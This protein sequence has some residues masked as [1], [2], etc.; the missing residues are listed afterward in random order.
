MLIILIMRLV[1]V[2][3]KDRHTRYM[4]LAKLKPLYLAL[5]FAGLFIPL[6]ASVPLLIVLYRL[7]NT[8]RRCPHCGTMMRKVDEVHDNEYL[9]PAQD[10]EEH[11]GSVDYDVWRVPPHAA[12]LI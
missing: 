5:T 6:V 2:R 9:N 3:G 1:A 12:R 4:E 8:P 7:R 11:I 10:L